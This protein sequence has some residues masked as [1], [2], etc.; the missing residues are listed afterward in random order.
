MIDSLT[1]SQVSGLRWTI[2][3]TVMVGGHLGAT[4]RMALDV[5]RAE[6]IGVGISRVRAELD[7]LEARK[8]VT[9]E[10]SEV[11]AWRVRLTRYGRDV[12]DYQVDVC[13][14]IT[15]P[16]RLDPYAE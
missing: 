1:P 11:Q 10:R 9:L 4:D 6:Y 12:V 8:L 7:Y 5:A 2:L 16:P 14:G 13:P 3:R 15:R